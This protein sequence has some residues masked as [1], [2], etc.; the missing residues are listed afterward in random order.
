MA[1]KTAVLAALGAEVFSIEIVA[2]LAQRAS[3]LLDALGYPVSLRVGDGYQGWPEE[4]PFAA[5]LLT[6][7]PPQLPPPLVAQLA[8]GGRLV[9]PVGEERQELV[10]V[11]RSAHEPGTAG[12]AE[13]LTHRSVYP[14]RFVPM[15]GLARAELR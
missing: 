6:A 3:A 4:Q 11:E 1:T 12:G 14:V 9:A 5:I 2:P 13:Q 8:P 7:A 15:T 10:V